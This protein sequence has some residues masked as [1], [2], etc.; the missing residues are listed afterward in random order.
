MLK[1]K[2]GLSTIPSTTTTKKHQ[3]LSKQAD[4]NAGVSK[5]FIIGGTS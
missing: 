4:G 3:K 5:F 1:Y 2:C